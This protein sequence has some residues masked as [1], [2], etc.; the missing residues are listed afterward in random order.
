MRAPNRKD[1]TI[2]GIK[3]AAAAPGTNPEEAT[4]AAAAPAAKEDAILS[5]AAN[6]LSDVMGNIDRGKALFLQVA[7]A[8][9]SCSPIFLFCFGFGFF[10]NLLG[11]QS[12]RDG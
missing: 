5:S 2:A 8:K 12:G 4:A 10:L 3:P 6:D 9:T 1:I 7:D 11:M